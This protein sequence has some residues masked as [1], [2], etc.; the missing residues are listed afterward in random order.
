MSAQ[1]KIILGFTGL[2][3]SGKGAAAKYLE[4]KH[5]A[6]TFR[7]SNM[8]RDILNRVYVPQARDNMIRLSEFLRGAYGEDI[9]AKTMFKDIAKDSAKVVVIE[10][11]R[12]LADIEQNTP[13]FVL[14][15]IFADP[16]IRYERLIKRGENPDDNS[17]TYEQFLADHKR[18]TEVSIL[19][20]IKH[21]T[22]KVDNNGDLADLHK[23]LDELVKKYAH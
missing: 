18:S 13:N 20:V 10:G 15:E 5:G 19:E 21:A 14:V 6:A 2:L 1:K 22:E 9:M 7:F 8:L 3:A 23:Q 16:K 11:I 17:K 4:A 12:R